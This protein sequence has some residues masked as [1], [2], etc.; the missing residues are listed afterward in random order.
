MKNLRRTF[1]LTMVLM[2]VL[3]S[4]ASASDV[5]NGSIR[6]TKP[7]MEGVPVEDPVPHLDGGFIKLLTNLFTKRS[8]SPIVTDSDV[9]IYD[10]GSN[11]NRYYAKGYVTMKQGSSDF[12]HYTRAENDMS[13]AI[14]V[15]IASDNKWGYGRVPAETPTYH[16][17]GTARIY[18]GW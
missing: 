14:G 13:Y 4:I 5:T 11:Y 10:N 15:I 9:A 18:Y 2:L 3:S 17:Y 12:R 8:D 7:F 6:V 1:A 16:A